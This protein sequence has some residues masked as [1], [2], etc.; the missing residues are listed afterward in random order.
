MRI[1]WCLLP[2]LLWGCGL[3]FGQSDRISDELCHCVSSLQDSMSDGTMDLLSKAS[4]SDS[5]QQEITLELN[6]LGRKEQAKVIDELTRY[7][8]LQSRNSP[9]RGCINKVQQQNLFLF[10]LDQK[11]Y[12]EG[13]V[14]QLERKNCRLA[15]ALLRSNLKMGVYK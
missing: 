8:L 5:P 13:L 12:I 7:G 2:L 3:G 14:D 1:G 10:A 4:Y 9:A 11:R 15:A 6:R